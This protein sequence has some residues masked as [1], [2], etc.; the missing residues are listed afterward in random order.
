MD[1]LT[2]L[3][4]LSEKAHC[5]CLFNVIFNQKQ[6]AILIK[7]YGT[8]KLPKAKIQLSYFRQLIWRLEFL[9]YYCC[10]L[11]TFNFSVNLGTISNASPTIP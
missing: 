3:I 1:N 7:K 5:A 2:K 10:A 8:K 9:N 6:Y 4:F 11:K